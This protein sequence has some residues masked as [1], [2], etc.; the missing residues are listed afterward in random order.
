MGNSFIEAMAAGIPVIGTPVGGIVD[1][2]KNKETGL[3]CDTKNPK[4]IADKVMILVQDKSLRDM[5]VIN[6]KML[7]VKKYDCNLVAQKMKN[8]LSTN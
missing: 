6:A 7:V 8:A 1:F 4:S 3:F 5:M 2:L